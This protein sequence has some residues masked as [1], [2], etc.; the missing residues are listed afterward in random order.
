MFITK[1]IFM[2]IL[3]IL[4]GL[5]SFYKKNYYVRTFDDILGREEDSKPTVRVGRGFVYGFFFPVYFVLALSGLAALIVFLV[6]A[7]IIAA[8]VFAGVWLTEKLIPVEWF[9]NVLNGFFSKIGL[10]SSAEAPAAPGYQ[11]PP[12]P[13]APADSGTPAESPSAPTP[14]KDDS[15]DNTGGQESSSFPGGGINRTRRHTLD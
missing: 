10:N 3:G 11:A 15:S 13:P 8:I 2:I 6:W 5:L 4:S 1:L 7:G 12:T 9:G 14:P